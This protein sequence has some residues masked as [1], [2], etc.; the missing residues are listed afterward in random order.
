VPPGRSP[1]AAARRRELTGNGFPGI[2][3]TV[4]TARFYYAL[5]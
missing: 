2:P 4:I 5:S 1:D 3:C